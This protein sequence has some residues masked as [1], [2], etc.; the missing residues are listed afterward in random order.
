MNRRQFR[1]NDQFDRQLLSIYEIARSLDSTIAWCREHN[2]L[3]EHAEC[4]QCGNNMII[5]TDISEIDQQIWIIII[6][7][8]QES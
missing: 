1:I 4:P 8:A 5:S 7:D 2:L 3:M 6:M